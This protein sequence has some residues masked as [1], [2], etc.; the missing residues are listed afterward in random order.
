MGSGHLKGGGIV[1]GRR[2]RVGV[3][4]AVRRLRHCAGVLP[5]R[6]CASALARLGES[7]VCGGFR[8]IRMAMKILWEGDGETC[9][10]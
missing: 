2:F 8:R 10:T 4:C 9:G 6:E 3:G 1:F 7:D 5:L